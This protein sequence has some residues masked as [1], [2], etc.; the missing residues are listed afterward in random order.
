MRKSVMQQ[1]ALPI[2]KIANHEHVNELQEIGRLLDV[3]PQVYE[4]IQADLVSHCDASKGRV[5][6]SAEQVLRV[7]IVK[8]INGFTYKEL[9]YHLADSFTYREF[10]R[11]GPHQLPSKSA[12]QRDIK[13]LR[14]ETLEG[15]N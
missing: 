8:Q 14:A 11:L 10:C 12:L 3:N 1:L 9:A 4:L 15:I 2:G 6:L 7:L 5:G 13:R